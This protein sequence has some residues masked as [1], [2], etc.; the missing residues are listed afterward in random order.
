MRAKAKAMVVPGGL[1]LVVAHG[2]G[3]F[4]KVSGK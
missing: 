1:V 3:S 4:L 2:A